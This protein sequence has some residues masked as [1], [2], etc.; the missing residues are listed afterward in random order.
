MTEIARWLEREIARG[1]QG[2]VALRLPGAPAE[3]A[4]TLTLDVWLAAIAVRAASWAEADDAH[5]I[6][7]GFR[8][9]YATCDRWPAPRQLLDALPIRAPPRA[10]PPPPMSAED[11]ARNRAR[12]DALMK[13]LSHKMRSRP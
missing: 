3:D 1:L 7:A 2:L 8:T 12:L 9:L 5:R 10:L 13:Q 4:I 6:R 11:R